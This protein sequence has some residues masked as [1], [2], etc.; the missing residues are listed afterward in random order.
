[1]ARAGGPT[2]TRPAST[3]APRKVGVLREEAVAGVD[4]LGAAESG[5]LDDGGSVEVAGRQQDGFIGLGH[6]GRV[7]VGLDVDRDRA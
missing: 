5:G 3:T 2:H 7:R 6:E 4:R 1:M